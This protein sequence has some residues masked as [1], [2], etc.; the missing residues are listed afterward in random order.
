MKVVFSHAVA[1]EA[2][3]LLEG[4]E[5]PVLNT[6]DMAENKA[7]IAD[8]DAIVARICHV[9]AEAIE[10]APNLKVIGRTGVGYDMVDVEAAT[11]RGIPVVLT[12]G[13]NNRSVAEHTV[14]LLFALSKNLVEGHNEQIKGNYAIRNKG[15]AFEL[16]D[17]TI[18]V[19]GLGAIGGEVARLCKAIGMKVIGYDPFL[20]EDKMEA[21]GCT[22]AKD[23]KAV[24]PECDFVTVHMPLLDSTRNMIGEKEIASMKPTAMIVNCAR[25]GIVDEKALAAALNEG[26][27][28]GA[29]IDCFEN[30]PPAVDDPLLNAKNVIASPHSA[31]QTKEAVIRMHKMCV[32]GCMAVCRGEKWPWVADKKVYEHPVWQGK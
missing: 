28:A 27:L 26:R 2:L 8:A 23:Y 6:R 3:A 12:P 22:P 32:E 21:L 14:A 9:S 20:P 19:L 1:P 11:Q 5:T 4:W 10:A 18:A 31:A 25:G 16:L 30:D 15:V 29:G 7:D 24:L 17:K 13:A